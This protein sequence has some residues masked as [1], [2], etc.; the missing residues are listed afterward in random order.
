M[1][2]LH[3]KFQMGVGGAETMLT[4]IMNVQV[5]HAKVIL[6][7]LYD[8]YSQEVLDRLDKKIT[9]IKIN[10]PRNEKSFKL[11]LKLNKTIWNLKPEIVHVHEPKA[12]KWFLP[13]VCHKMV[14]TVHSI[15]LYSRWWKRC[16]PIF[17]ISD[18][19]HED[20]IQHGFNH[21][22]TVYNGINFEEISRKKNYLKRHDVFQIVCVGRFLNKKKG[23]DLLIKAMDV[24]VHQYHLTDIHLDLIG[25]GESEEENSMLIQKCGLEQYVAMLVG[26]ERSYIYTHLKDYDLSVQ[27]SLIEGFG[28]TVVESIAAGLPVLVS[29]TNGPIE[30]IDHGKYGSF[31]ETGNIQSLVENLMDIYHNYSE[32]A[33]ILDIAIPYMESKYS[34]VQTALQYLAYY[35]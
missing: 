24:L 16:N 19:V 30:I 28:L 5:Q 10:A 4:D 23:Q 18:T 8:Y 12:P 33:H 17:A 21:V 32:K 14:G 20:L 34:V 26:K 22:Q 11:L 1:T 35:E 31:F 3:F 25:Y 13:L 9:I 29:D 27:P 7:I 2:I 6:V 15:Q